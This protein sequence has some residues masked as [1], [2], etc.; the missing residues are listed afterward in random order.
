M[1]DQVS[2]QSLTSGVDGG[3]GFDNESDRIVQWVSRQQC[4]PFRSLGQSQGK[5]GGHSNEAL[6]LE[7]PN[8]ARLFVRREPVDGAYPPYDVQGE[9]RLLQRLAG[10]L[11]VPGI[12]AICDGVE[13]ET[14]PFVVMDWCDGVVELPVRSRTGR[15][16]HE[17]EV[18]M[19]DLLDGLVTIHSFP[20]ME[21]G[22][23]DL[24][25]V[26]SDRSHADRILDRWEECLGGLSFSPPAVALYGLW[27][28]RE[29][30]PKGGSGSMQLVHGDYR[31]G[32]LIWNDRR[33]T[34]LDWEDATLGDPLFDLGWLCMGAVQSDDLVMGIIPKDQL[35]TMYQQKLGTEI[36]LSVLSWWEAL[37]A[38]QR[39]CMEAR[40]VDFQR[41]RASPDLRTLLWEVASGQTSYELLARISM[42]ERSL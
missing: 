36:D 38:W 39:L 10:H 5:V 1:Q 7:S 17:A 15:T 42:M 22:L 34:V 25:H 32:N 20:V 37:A 19:G 8:G 16:S 13:S 27:W 24:M 41:H 23:V 6:I 31:L 9:G 30:P 18:L 12:V 26:T 29:H 4:A 35:L 28:L 33:M 2:A 11:L 3:G 14:Q 40:G 21:E